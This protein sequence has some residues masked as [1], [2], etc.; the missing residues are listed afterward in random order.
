MDRTPFAP[1]HSPSYC[2]GY[3]LR[4]HIASALQARSHTTKTALER[5]NQ[6]AAA[7]SPARPQ[8]SWNEVVGYAFL[9]DFDLLRDSRRDTRERPRS[10]P[11]CRVPM[12]CF[13]KT[14][15]A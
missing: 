5:Y 13:F 10:K 1:T 7:L 6:A 9:A 14:V 11:A 4:K 2:V 3:K 12:V 15:R 8:L